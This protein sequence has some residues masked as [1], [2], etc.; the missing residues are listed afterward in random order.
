M[1]RQRC[2]EALG[3]RAG[4][5]RVGA[6]IAAVLRLLS[7]LMA[8]PPFPGILSDLFPEVAHFGAPSDVANR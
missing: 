3:G 6:G 5:G 8:R 7:P 4:G 1:P 2:G